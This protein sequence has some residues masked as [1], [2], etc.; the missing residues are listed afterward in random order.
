LH[1]FLSNFVPSPHT[2]SLFRTFLPSQQLKQL[3]VFLLKGKSSFEKN[4]FNQSKAFE[5]DSSPKTKKIKKVKEKEKTKN[6]SN[7]RQ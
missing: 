2:F 5:N 6:R 3:K 7:Q 1:S 4:L